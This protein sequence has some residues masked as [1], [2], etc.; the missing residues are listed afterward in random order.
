MHPKFFNLFLSSSLL[1]QM[2]ATSAFAESNLAAKKTLLSAASPAKHETAGAS[3]SSSSSSTAVTVRGTG[4]P[5]VV[6]TFN[7]VYNA[8]ERLRSDIRAAADPKNTDAEIWIGM[9]SWSDDFLLV[10]TNRTLL[11]EIKSALEK[12]PNLKVYVLLWAMP[13]GTKLIV[14]LGWLPFKEGQALKDWPESMKSRFQLA[15]QSLLLTHPLSSAHQKFI[16]FRYGGESVGY[17]LDYNFD[18]FHFDWPDHDVLRRAQLGL[19]VPPVHDTAMRFKGPVIADFQHEFLERW[20][21]S[22]KPKEGPGAGET[23]PIQQIPA[24]NPHLVANFQRPGTKG[25]DIK[26]WYVNAIRNAK[27]YIYLESQYFDNNEI[28]DELIDAYYRGLKDPAPNIVFTLCSTKTVEPKSQVD[29]SLREVMR[30]RLSTADEI[31]LMSGRKIKRS[32]PWGK[33]V[34]SKHATKCELEGNGAH[35]KI[36][37]RNIKK[38][39]GGVRFVTMVTHSDTAKNNFQPIYV[40]SKVGLIDDQMTIGSA[41]QNKRSFGEDYEANV[42]LTDIPSTHVVETF[43]QR[44]LGSAIDP[45]ISGTTLLQKIDATAR[46][47]WE[48][49]HAGPPAPPVGLVIDYPYRK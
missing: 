39:N 49:R 11:S 41:N 1:L 42:M 22:N 15:S 21:L 28:A 40:H 36:K 6:E 9:W 27:N 32:A 34:V 47:N 26:D 13:P 48:R 2:S 29:G 3:A 12:N 4:A 33:V 23:F 14:N 35:Y 30:V 16:L 10:E 24:D 43:K 17:C 37:F 31:E 5:H 46:K 18:N 19:K 7:D 8:N 44:L 25:G 38:I 45:K 20:A